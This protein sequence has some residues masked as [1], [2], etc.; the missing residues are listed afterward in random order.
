MVDVAIAVATPDD[1][2][3]M[4]QSVNPFQRKLII[5]LGD[6]TVQE[7]MERS[8]GGST[9]MWSARIGGQLVAMWGVYPLEGG[10]GYPW[11]YSTEAL[12]QF[13]KLALE[14][15]RI[16]IDEML[17]LHPRLVGTVD[18]RFEASVRFAE[19][20]GFT[21]GEYPAEPPFAVIERR[22]A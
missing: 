22:A 19:H 13:P 9:A 16:A 2:A 10:C 4:A 15:G 6:K 8:F 3:L 5:A 18:T 20:L 21:V 7:C 17:H 1:C 12:A 14:V 11:L